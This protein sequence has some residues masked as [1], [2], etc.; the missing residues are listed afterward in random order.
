MERHTD[1]PTE[2]R[3]EKLLDWIMPLLRK[4]HWSVIKL[5]Q[6]LLT[7]TKHRTARGKLIQALREDELFMREI[8]RSEK[9][10]RDQVKKEL[11]A[12]SYSLALGKY[13]S[14]IMTY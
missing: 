1:T 6:S 12:I 9:E 4:K 7:S 2:Q 8:G 14:V 13:K 5:V 11:E 10:F 3:D